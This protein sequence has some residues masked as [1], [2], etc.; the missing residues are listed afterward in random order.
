MRSPLI[1]L[2]VFLFTIFV[3]TGFYLIYSNS[4]LINGEQ[5]FFNNLINSFLG[6]SVLAIVTAAIFIF[7]DHIENKRQKQNLIY[8]NKIE[9]YK[10]LNDI[11]SSFSTTKITDKNWI[12]FKNLEYGF[13][14]I[15]SEAEPYKKHQDLWRHLQK[16]FDKLPESD[17]DTEVFIRFT[18]DLQDKFRD[19]FS[20]IGDDL[21][22]DSNLPEKEILKKKEVIKDYRET[23]LFDTFRSIE[24]K[25]KK[26]TDEEKKKVCKIYRDFKGSPELA[27]KM[28][29]HQIYANYPQ[30]VSHFEKSLKKKA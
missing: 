29:E 6:A 24:S 25:R 28:A 30:R 17:G 23:H 7:Q 21:I 5:E 10:K 27:E 20:C 2:S 11:V 18:D 9:F 26:W 14:L 4:A 3:L 12:E 22:K 15:D 1:F 8:K 13:I 16:E 19:L